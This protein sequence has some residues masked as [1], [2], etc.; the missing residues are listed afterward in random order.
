MANNTK[1]SFK[2]ESDRQKLKWC[3]KWTEQKRQKRFLE[4]AFVGERYMDS[5][6]FQHILLVVDYFC[7]A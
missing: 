6:T 4:Q 1:E 3:A 2:E 5:A 7:S